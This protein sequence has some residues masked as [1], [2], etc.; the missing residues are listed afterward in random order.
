[1]RIQ[2]EEIMLK[3]G[4]IALGAL[5]LLSGSPATVSQQ[6]R[7]EEIHYRDSAVSYIDTGTSSGTMESMTINYS[8]RTVQTHTLALRFPE[9]SYSPASGSCAAIA[10]GNLIGFF[11]RYDEN[12]IPNHSSGKTFGNTYLYSLQD[13]AVQTVIYELYDYM[14]TTTSGTTE[15]QFKNGLTNFCKD[16]GHSITFSS[17]MQGSSFSY[18]KAQSYLDANQPVALFLSG[19]NVIDLEEY[20]NKDIFSTYVSEAP[21]IMI[22]FGYKVYVYD[23]ITY[24]YFSVASGNVGHSSGLYNID[25]KT[26]INNALAVNIS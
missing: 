12:L 9:Y 6:E 5:L 10:G 8:T 14:G 17:C 15:Q 19:Y 18:S 3:L 26:K 22:A 16:K 13:S 11:D 20:E 23:G 1:M 2:E 7:K 24:S 21:H 4:A 25:Y